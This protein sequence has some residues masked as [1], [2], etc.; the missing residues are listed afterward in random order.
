MFA[1]FLGMY[2]GRIWFLTLPESCDSSGTESVLSWVCPSFER[3]GKRNHVQPYSK[4][5]IQ[6]LNCIIVE[7]QARSLRLGLVGRCLQL[8]H[9]RA[10]MECKD[11]LACSPMDRQNC[12]A[13]MVHHLF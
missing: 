2:A 5:D 13:T 1:K 9:S 10:S 11:S 3:I 8:A 4:I 7:L 12:T 6:R